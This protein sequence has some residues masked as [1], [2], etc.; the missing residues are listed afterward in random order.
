MYHKTCRP[1]PSAQILCFILSCMQYHYHLVCGCLIKKSDRVPWHYFM[2][3][4]LNALAREAHFPRHSGTHAYQQHTHSLFY[5]IAIT[6]VQAKRFPKTNL[7]ENLAVIF[8]QWHGT[9]IKKRYLPP[10][11]NMMHY[12]YPQK[13]N[14]KVQQNWHLRILD[15][16]NC[17]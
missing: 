13:D 8:S 12:N 6:S 17:S 11:C 2:A 7:S 16:T 1:C 15:K 4:V 3:Y 9:S 10:N 14:Y 5:P